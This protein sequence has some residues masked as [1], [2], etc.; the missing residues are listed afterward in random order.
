MKHADVIV[1]GAGPAGCAAAWDLAHAGLDVLLLDRKAFPRTKPCAGGLTVKALLRLRYSVAPVIQ[2]V[3]S[4]IEVTRNGGRVSRFRA[5]APMVAMTVRR[6]LDAYCLDQTLAKG[7][8]LLL[9]EAAD[10]AQDA[11]GVSLTTAKGETLRARWLVGADGANSRVRRLIGMAPGERALALEGHVPIPATGAP[12]LRF[13]FERVRGGYGWIFPKADH[14][15]VGLYTQAPGVTF[16][17]SDLV[18]YA[19]EAAGAETVEDMVGYPLGIGG[20]GYAPP[21]GR[22]LLAG[23]AAGMAER[24]L[25]EGLHNAI[26]SGQTAAAAILAA[27]AE[28]DPVRAHRRALR[29]IQADLHACNA[30]AG[31]LYSGH[32]LGW[33]AMIS[34]PGKSALSR[35]FAAGMT[36]AEILPTSPFALAYPVADLG[37]RL[38][39]QA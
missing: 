28:A 24:L 13:D 25:G 15:N 22:V 7:A 33:M 26:K 32:P 19:R 31:W 38:P 6:E 16:G 34:P 4:E 5:R 39:A 3:I 29:P 8:R 21:P 37:G 2:R 11:E 27:E 10:V 36:L 23:D 18:A 1:V 9:A 20:A 17:K 35:G 30:G 12:H 14:L